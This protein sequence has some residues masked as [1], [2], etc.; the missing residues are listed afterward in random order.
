MSLFPP[1]NTSCGFVA[2]AISNA[3]RG[4]LVPIPNQ[5]FKKY[6]FSVDDVAMSEPTVKLFEVVAMSCPDELVV[7]IELAAYVPVF[8]M[9]PLSLLNHESLT[10][11]E[12]MVFTC[13]LVPVYANPCPSDER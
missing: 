5:L 13:P 3:Y 12:A 8:V 4:V 9:N 6:E 2:V 10:E 1:C 7:M 11:E